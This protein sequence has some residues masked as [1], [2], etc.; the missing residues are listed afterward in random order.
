VLSQRLAGHVR[1]IDVR[2]APDG[3]ID[4]EHACALPLREHILPE[5]TLAWGH[6]LP[7]GAISRVALH[8]IDDAIDVDIYLPLA[9]ARDDRSH[10]QDFR[11]AVARRPEIGQ[12]R[13]FY[14]AAHVSDLSQD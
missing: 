10:Q 5:L 6:L 2:V 8:Y 4:A 3:L 12:L 13:L 7:A 14:T 9:Y 11:T 1:C